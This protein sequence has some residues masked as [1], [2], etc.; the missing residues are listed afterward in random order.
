[1]GNK[2]GLLIY[3]S[4]AITICLRIYADP[5]HYT[6]PDSHHYLEEAQRIISTQEPGIFDQNTTFTTWPAGYPIL[7]AITSKIT[8]TTP[9]I[10]SKLL[11]L[12]FLALLFLLLYHWFGNTAWFLSLYFTSY[13]MLEIYSH[14]WAD[15]PFLFFVLLLCYILFKDSQ[16]SKTRPTLFFE[17]FLCLVALFLLR[18]AGAIYILPVGVLMVVQHIKSNRIKTIHYAIA[19][20]LSSVVV[21][22]YFINNK[23][24]SGFYFGSD[25]IE[26]SSTTFIHILSEIL[27]GT[28][29]EL[30]IARNYYFKGN[31]DYLYILLVFI[32]GVVIVK[33][34]RS[35]HV[36]QKLF[37]IS[38]NSKLLIF[39]GAFYFIILLVLRSSHIITE[40]NYRILAPATT[41]FYI[42]LMLSVNPE[43][44]KEYFYQIKPWIVGFMVLSLIINL[45][46]Q[47]LINM[48]FQ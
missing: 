47:Y 35:R 30:T 19:I 9:L 4:V 1:M 14:T 45:P 13:S 40:F 21:I 12:I 15:G 39:T 29:N 28:I 23:I 22:A 27:Q 44:Q 26:S 8:F 25:R 6:T 43:K 36:F 34:W 46:K 11:N 5:A 32:Q 20:T 2:A 3:I 42:V 33:L 18:Y 16:T 31:I 7:I 10:A 37:P 41:L 24:M 48:L 17:L 38:Q